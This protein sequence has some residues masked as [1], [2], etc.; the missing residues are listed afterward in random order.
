MPVL[1]SYLIG[2]L[3][4][5]VDGG[6]SFRLAAQFVICCGRTVVS[7]LSISS[8]SV[9]RELMHG[10]DWEVLTMILSS[11][12]SYEKNV[13]RTTRGGGVRR[14]NNENESAEQKSI[15]RIQM[16]LSI[17][18]I[19]LGAWCLLDCAPFLCMGCDWVWAQGEMWGIDHHKTSQFLSG[20]SIMFL[21]F[22][23]AILLPRLLTPLSQLLMKSPCK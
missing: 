12:E 14:M 11:E 10:S 13:S 17:N 16:Q 7:F 20:S 18:S 5:L 2:R 4:L 22:H 23:C 9:L 19:C 15:C 1:I 3:G 21:R 8:I 6:I